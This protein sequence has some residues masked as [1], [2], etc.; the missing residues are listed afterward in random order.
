MMY[1]SKLSHKLMQAY[2]LVV[3]MNIRNILETYL[4]SNP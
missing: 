1:G 3:M 4:K 2:K